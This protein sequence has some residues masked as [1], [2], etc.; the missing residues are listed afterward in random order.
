MMNL[1]MG[2]RYGPTTPPPIQVPQNIDPGTG[3]MGQA[4]QLSGVPMQQPPMQ[5]PMQP[6]AF[7]GLN[8]PLNP[9]LLRALQSLGYNG[10]LAGRPGMPSM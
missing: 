4:M 1:G 10:L 9:L 3:Y 5:K 7:G 8:T 6:Q 2:E